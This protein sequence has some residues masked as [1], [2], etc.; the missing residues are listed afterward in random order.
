MST[1]TY[2][3]L[4]PDTLQNKKVKEIMRYTGGHRTSTLWSEETDLSVLK[5]R[6]FDKQAE[7]HQ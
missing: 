3:K 7:N 1:I 2:A 5:T 6:S 4:A